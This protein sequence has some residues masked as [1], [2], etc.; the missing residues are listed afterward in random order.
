MW[1]YIGIM[2]EAHLQVCVHDIPARYDRTLYL[3]SINLLPVGIYILI[4]C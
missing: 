3:D 1:D 2:C 4:F